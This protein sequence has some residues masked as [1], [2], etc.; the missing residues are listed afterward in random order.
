MKHVLSTPETL[1][2]YRSALMGGVASLSLLIAGAAYAQQGPSGAEV[3]K[4]LGKEATSAL[5]DD[6]QILTL[7]APDSRRIYITDPAHFAVTTQTFTV[8]ADNA[9]VLSIT[10]GGFLANPFAADR[11]S[12]V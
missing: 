12:V 10:D 2:K 7:P 1:T 11:K 5:E 4:Q 3:P 9:K 6:P 8:D